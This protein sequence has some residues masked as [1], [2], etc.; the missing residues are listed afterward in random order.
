MASSKQSTEEKK[1][2]ET[3]PTKSPKRKNGTGTT[4]RNPAKDRKMGNGTV[5][6]SN[7][8]VS[9]PSSSIEF[10]EGEQE[11]SKSA[12]S[13]GTAH[14]AKSKRGK[15]KKREEEVNNVSDQEEEEVGEREEVKMHR[16][17]M[18]RMK[19][20]I[21]GEDS[22]LRVTQEALFILNKA[23]EKF[24]EQFTKDAYGC[25]VQD[26]KKSIAYKHLSSVVGKRRRYDFLSDFVPEKIKAEDAL[27]QRK[28]TETEA[29]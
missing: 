8:V 1:S 19:T 26:R 11:R 28:S 29:D 4:K 27:S 23:T 20:I 14:G 12:S 2:K 7:G 21:R 25:C 5:S 6:K 24:L 9:V 10:R 3:R 15:R 13:N 18:H 16:F 17:P 22:D